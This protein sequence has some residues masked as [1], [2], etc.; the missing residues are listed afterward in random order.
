MK[1]LNILRKQTQI[2][3]ISDSFLNATWEILLL[4]FL[5][6]IAVERVLFVFVVVIV[7][8]CIVYLSWRRKTLQQYILVALVIEKISSKTKTI[9]K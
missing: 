8:K 9:L 7:E 4:L 1:N 3:W 2:K 5:F 6:I